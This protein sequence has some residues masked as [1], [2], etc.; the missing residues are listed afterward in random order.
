MSK[1]SAAETVSRIFWAFIEEPSWLQPAL[2]RRVGVSVRTLRA[3]L[4]ELERG[5]V[6]LDW[7]EDAAP[8]EVSHPARGANRK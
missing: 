6:P 7:D 1:R 2:A 4:E 8:R 5:G 3:R